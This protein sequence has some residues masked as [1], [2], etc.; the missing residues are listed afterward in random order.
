MG[1]SIKYF[2]FGSIQ[3]KEHK[4]AWQIK[5]FTMQQTGRQ[6]AALKFENVL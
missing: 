3:E 5:A 1:N 4:R 2:F 6:E